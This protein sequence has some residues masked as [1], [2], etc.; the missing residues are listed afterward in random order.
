[1]GTSVNLVTIYPRD[2]QELAL[3]VDFLQRRTCAMLQDGVTPVHLR[4]LLAED[5]VEMLVAKMTHSN[6]WMARGIQL[7]ISDE[8]KMASSPQD[9]RHVHST[10]P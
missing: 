6:R 2:G 8:E 9:L 4:V 5:L 3:K 1:M 7:A 10:W